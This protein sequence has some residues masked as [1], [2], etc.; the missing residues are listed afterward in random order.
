[1]FFRDLLRIAVTVVVLLQGANALAQTDAQKL[2]VLDATF[3]LNKYPDLKAAFGNDTQAAT[4]HWLQNGYKEGRDSSPNFS[5]GGYRARYPDLQRAINYDYPALLRHWYDFGIK[6][7]RDPRAA[8]TYMADP[9]MAPLDP[10]FYLANN[11]ELP[12]AIGMNV[13]RLVDHWLN[14]GLPQGRAPNAVA[15]AKQVNLDITFYADR[16]PDLKQAFAYDANKLYFHWINNGRAEGRSP[17][18]ATYNLMLPAPRSANGLSVLR[19]GDYMKPGDF[20]ISNNRRFI[21]AFQTD[22][23]L[24]VYETDNPA[25]ASDANRRWYQHPRSFDTKK[26]Y[27]MVLQP[28]GHFCTYEGSS[29]ADQGAYVGCVPDK[30]GGPI[31]RYFVALQDDGNLVVYKGQGPDD[32]RGWIWDRITTLPSKGFNYKAIVENVDSVVRAGAAAV[33]SAANEVAH[34]TVDVS[35]KVANTTTSVAVTVGREVE[36]GG[37][38]VGREVVRNGEIVGYAV[39]NFAQDAWSYLRGNCGVIGRKAFPIDAY[40]KGASTVAN[41]V[42]K[43][44]NTGGGAQLASAEQ[45]FNWAQD[46]FYCAIPAEMEKVVS[47]A[48]SMPGN[49][50]NLSTKIFNEA[51]SSECLIAGAATAMM[52]AVGL[53]MCAFT[54]VVVNDAK[55]AYAC[56]AAAE[57]KGIMAKFTGGSSNGFPS[58]KA[59]TAAGQL[60]LK[61]SEKVLTDDLSDQVKLA[62]KSG[63]SAALVAEQLL[64]VYSVSGQGSNYENLVNELHKLPECN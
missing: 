48:A 22:A 51:K 23:N 61:V 52:G 40:F 12:A 10:N 53:E 11:S 21:L 50:V 44:G 59:C 38:I 58:Q 64:L 36:Q 24:V 30:A 28:D 45:C 31:G 1:M 41:A 33:T 17:N 8:G 62:A 3:Y 29:T 13:P 57:A 25:K 35:N 9:A 34:T 49:M 7:K 60:A 42:I 2:G 27:F 37:Q 16:Y 47:Q 15:A 4:Q 46:G 39:S 32:N 20:M 56:Y 55:G 18:L 54:K 63:K 14:Y 43:Y 6:E 19:L 5:L 26:K